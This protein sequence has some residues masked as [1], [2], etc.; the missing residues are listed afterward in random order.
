MH[1]ERFVCLRKHG[2]GCD[3]FRASTASKDSS[4]PKLLSNKAEKRN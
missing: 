4:I 1:S 3:A 2:R